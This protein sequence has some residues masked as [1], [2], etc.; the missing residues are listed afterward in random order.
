MEAEQVVLRV[1]GPKSSASGILVRR[2][3]LDVQA[4]AS[5]E[6]QRVLLKL[7]IKEYRQRDERKT[8]NNGKE[9]NKK[10][11]LIQNIKLECQ[12]S[13][14]VWGKARN[15]HHLLV[16][17]LRYKEANLLFPLYELQEENACSDKTYFAIICNI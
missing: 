6:R 7:M 8:N 12:M 4:Y 1:V 11:L 14:L 15:P 5:G 9:E 3:I 13:I 17:C 10:V 2:N 16:S